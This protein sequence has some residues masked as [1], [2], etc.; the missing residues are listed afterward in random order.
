M[1]GIPKEV[2]RL[3]IRVTGGKIIQAVTDKVAPPKPSKEPVMDLTIVGV[4][5]HLLQLGAGALLARGVIDAS[6]VDLI[7]G[8]GVSLVTLGSYLVKRYSARKA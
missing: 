1:L 7:V 8:A 3:L 5:R 2:G 6:G 4:V